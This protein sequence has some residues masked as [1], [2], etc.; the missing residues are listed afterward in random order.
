MLVGKVKS[1]EALDQI[2]RRICMPKKASGQLDVPRE[3]YEK[4]KAKGEQRDELMN[5]L[6]KVGGNKVWTQSF[7]LLACRHSS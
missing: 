3:I 5:E 4:Y 1:K 7:R 2:L 6:I